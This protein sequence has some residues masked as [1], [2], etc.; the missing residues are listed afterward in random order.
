MIQECELMI[1]FDNAATTLKKPEAVVR[2]VADAVCT[3][4]N[5]S[6][7]SHEASLSGMRILYKTRAML[8]EMF[9]GDSPER[10]VFTANATMALNMTIQ[11]MF[12]PGDHVITTALEHNSVLR[13]LY[14]M[15][16]RG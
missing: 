11:G 16:S 15:E 3:V 14:L 2:A 9:H 7:G 4:G 1:Y 12:N 8:C 6:R 5:A 13:P 10:T